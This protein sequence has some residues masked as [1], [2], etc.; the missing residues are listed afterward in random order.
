MPVLQSTYALAEVP[1]RAN[2]QVSMSQPG[3]LPWWLHLP[4]AVELVVGF[5]LLIAGSILVILHAHSALANIAIVH[6]ILLKKLLQDRVCIMFSKM[7]LGSTK[8]PLVAT[9]V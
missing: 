3:R 9:A 5:L 4:A 1:G 2:S 8:K 7:G 6:R